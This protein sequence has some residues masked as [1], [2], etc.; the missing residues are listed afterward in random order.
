VLAGVAGLTSVVAGLALW[1]Q[2]RRAIT[3]GLLR[4]VEEQ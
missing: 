4:P 3:I 1:Q 2:H